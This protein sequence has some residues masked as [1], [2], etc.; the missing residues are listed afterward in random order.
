MLRIKGK[1]M[2][3]IFLSWYYET[4]QAVAITNAAGLLPASLRSQSQRR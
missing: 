4:L 2:I 1:K 3:R